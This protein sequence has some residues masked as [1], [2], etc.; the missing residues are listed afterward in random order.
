LQINE[1]DKN[2]KVSKSDLSFSIIKD[3]K[4]ITNENGELTFKVTERNMK[5]NE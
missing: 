3:K 5:F 4:E 2:F 1:S